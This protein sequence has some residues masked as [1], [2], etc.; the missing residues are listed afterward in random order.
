[1]SLSY[2]AKCLCSK[3]TVLRTEWSEL[4]CKT[5]LF[6]TVAEKYSSSDVS[7]ILLTD[8]KMFT[9]VTP[10]KRIA[11]CMQIQQPRRKTMPQ[12]LY[13]HDQRSNVS[14]RVTS[15]RENTSLILVDHGVNVIEGCYL[16]VML[17]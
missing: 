9:V 10:K 11:N 5:Q 6:E 1:M 13:T 8:E 4:L 7:T 16:N 15:G 17:L 14:Q 12:N 2:L 3:I